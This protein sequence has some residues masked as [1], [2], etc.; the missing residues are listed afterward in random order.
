MSDPEV[1]WRVESLQAWYE[2]IEMRPASRD[3]DD[4]LSPYLKRGSFRDPSYQSL[5]LE[6]AS[7]ATMPLNRL[8]GLVKFYQLAQKVTHVNAADQL[9]AGHWLRSDLFL[10]ADRPFH[11]VLTR[12]AVY[13]SQITRS[14]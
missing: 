5:W 12:I 6:E 14:P 3:Y 11:S 2:A 8:I 13:T 10:T 4:W 1:F 7:G 9:H